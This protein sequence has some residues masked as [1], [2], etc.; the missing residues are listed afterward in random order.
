[1]IPCLP[2]S[3]CILIKL[4]HPHCWLTAFLKTQ[5]NKP[6]SSTENK[7]KYIQ[8][9]Q[10]FFSHR[11][12]TYVKPPRW[13]LNET[14]LV[15]EGV[16]QRQFNSV[17]VWNMCPRNWTESN[18]RQKCQDEDQSDLISNLPVF[19]KD[20]DVTYRNIF[21]ARC[22]GAPLS[23]K[24]WKIQFNCDNSLN[25][26]TFSLLGNETILLP[27]DC[28]IEK[29]PDPLHSPRNPLKQCIPRFQR[30]RHT[31]LEN[32]SRCETDC[33]RY[34]LPVC[35]ANIRSRN[36]HCALCAGFELDELNC[37]CDA[38]SMGG[39]PSL[40]MLFDF[41][42]TSK[43][44][45]VVR[46]KR[47]YV[48]KRTKKEFSCRFDQVY[49]PYAGTCKKIASTEFLTAVRLGNRAKD[50]KQKR[51]NRTRL[52]LN[53][54]S[55]MK[56]ETGYTPTGSHHGHRPSKLNESTSQEWNENCTGLA[57]NKTEYVLLSNGSV[58]LKL[59]K[60]MYSNMTYNI[61]NKTLVLCVNFSR[62]YTRTENEGDKQTI[63]KTPAS[64][65]LLTLI[66]CIVSTVS[67]VL[68]LITYLVFAELRNL[69]GKIITN[70][71]LS[72]LLYQTVFFLA[73]KK[74]NQE[75]CLAIA[76]LLHFFVLSSFMWM[77]VMAYDMRRIFTNASGSLGVVDVFVLLQLT[78]I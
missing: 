38:D 7:P 43:Y 41:T 16:F 22:N 65:Q 8:M 2:R 10:F 15:Y 5:H 32:G 66:G 54:T 69:P 71:T 78:P 62:N 18:V 56:N 33:P 1:M 21:C 26:T 28:W 53:V 39:V 34:A 6:F 57:F 14:C 70:L 63:T 76:V 25:A 64:F 30:C 3:R 17:A 75:T 61:H 68:L 67:L 44:S 29:F 59:H 11:C 13:P 31:T 35:S 27:R 52:Q 46:D 9:R 47:H 24:F 74:D 40:T 55:I 4:L 50:I 36:P 58:Y 48:F 49:D 72:L 45:V 51:R 19:D 23:A 12:R 73:L 60:K 77:N 42:S 20:R 37:T